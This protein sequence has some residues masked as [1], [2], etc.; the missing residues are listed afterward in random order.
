MAPSL[1]ER[2]QQAPQ[3]RRAEAAGAV[4]AVAAVVAKPVDL[5]QPQRVARVEQVAMALS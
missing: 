5:L 1:Q 4:V 3:A 2:R